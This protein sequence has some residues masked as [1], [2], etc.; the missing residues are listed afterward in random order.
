MMSY[1]WSLWL[2]LSVLGAQGWRLWLAVFPM[3]PVPTTSCSFRK[4]H[5]HHVSFTAS[6]FICFGAAVW[7]H[8]AH[9]AI[10]C[11]AHFSC[12]HHMPR[13]PC[14]FLLYSLPPLPCRQAGLVVCFY[15][16]GQGSR[17]FYLNSC[18][19][20]SQ[21]S[22]PS[23]KA[24]DFFLSKLQHGLFLYF[25]RLLKIQKIVQSFFYYFTS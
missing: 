21:T 17:L 25:V 13:C 23:L 19:R 5:S 14:V 1:S 18:V 20:T 24:S 12:V 9:T 16:H 7:G 22:L 10:V 8:M 11:S 4:L 15:L 3:L 2:V 6:P